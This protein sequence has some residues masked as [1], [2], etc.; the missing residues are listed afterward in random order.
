MLPTISPR[1]AFEMLKNGEARLVDIRETA[2][3]AENFIPGARLVPLSIA[4]IYP[5][6]DVD[7]PDKPVIFFCR[8]GNRTD[9]ASDLLRSLVGDAEAW[10]MEG[11]L[12]GWQKEGLPVQHEK[13]PFP[14]FRQ[15][16]IGAGALVLL[17]ILG[18]YVWHPMYWLSAF[19][20]AGLVFAG[21][22]GFCG[23]G[24]LLARMPWNKK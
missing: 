13:V 23:L 2:E 20:G 11:G 5:L 22:T 1:R 3:Y 4:K 17:G 21:V 19:V 10:Q 24:L 6:K 7:A 9:K 18:S 8:S 16:Q 12:S 15:I 14:L